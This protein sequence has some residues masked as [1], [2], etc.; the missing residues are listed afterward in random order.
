[1]NQE[2]ISNFEALQNYYKFMNDKGRDIAYGK[3]VRSL[4]NVLNP[5]TSVDQVR[6]L[7]GVGSKIQAKINE[8]LETG[9]IRCVDE[10]KAE[11]KTV[12]RMTTKEKIIRSFQNIWGVGPVK[13]MQ[14]YSAGFRSIKD[15]RK[16]SD[17]LTRSQ[18]IGMKYYGDLMKKISR[19]DIT[20]LFSFLSKQL[21]GCRIEIAGSY[22]RGNS[23]C[24]DIDLLI[25][26]ENGVKITL[27]KVVRKL[28]K[29]GV[30]TDTLSMRDHKFMGIVKC[31]SGQYAR[32]D[33]EYVPKESWGSAM[34]YFT[35]PKAN[36]VY[37]R[38]VAKRKG[39]LLNEYGIY[40]VKTGK[41]VD[42]NPSEE[43][44][45]T[46]LGLPYRSPESR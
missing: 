36:N 23:M 10:K 31:P 42:T 41:K 7:S 24:G 46:I 28:E 9:R 21:S 26:C 38:G 3:V 40:W 45:F 30:I 32:L 20:R 17:V 4:R 5:I 15:L 14:L 33:I 12:N 19:D 6:G 11:M 35:G 34:L 44:I 22:R 27:K 29:F 18:R 37:M 13:A 2:L 25:T 39:L 16:N 1:M 8:F 43:D